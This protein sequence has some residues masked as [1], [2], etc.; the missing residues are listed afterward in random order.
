MI[1]IAGAGGK[2]GQ[3]IIQATVERGAV[4]RAF[5]YREEHVARV[6]GLG[7]QEVVVG[8]MRDGTAYQNAT[9]EAR[10]VYHICPNVSPD[11]IAIGQAAIQ[12][13]HSSGVGRFVY[14]SVLH[15]Q[16][17][18]MPHHWKKLRVEEKLLASGLEHIILQPA[19]YMHNILA[20]WDSVAE[21][22]IYPVPYSAEARSAP[23]AIHVH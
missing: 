2:T 9:H 1:V 11:E 17:E 16:T 21:K 23:H 8:D 3:A 10:A 18:E 20:Y 7:A 15:P 13:A 6:S 22:G 12:A 14:H 5:V 4:V 19:P